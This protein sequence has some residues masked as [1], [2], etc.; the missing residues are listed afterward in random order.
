MKPFYSTYDRRYSV[1]WDLFNESAWKA[2][3]AE[4]KAEKKK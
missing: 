1:Y 4:Y 2:K 3:E